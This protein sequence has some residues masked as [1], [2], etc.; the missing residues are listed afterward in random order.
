MT[1]TI[2][3]VAS[4]SSGRTWIVFPKKQYYH[5]YVSSDMRTINDINGRHAI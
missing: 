5:E 2:C 4:I 3:E 1:W